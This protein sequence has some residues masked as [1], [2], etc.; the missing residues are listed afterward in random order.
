MKTL[1]DLANIAAAQRNATLNSP[2]VQIFKTRLE[3][4]IIH[5]YQQSEG[6]RTELHLPS[7][8]YSLSWLEKDTIKKH[9][10]EM[11]VLAEMKHDPGQGRS[12]EA[13]ILPAQE[14]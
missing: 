11:G 8:Y 10:R 1:K 5:A 2:A 9:L 4:A 12:W 6:R 13:W 14:T 3:A 7:G